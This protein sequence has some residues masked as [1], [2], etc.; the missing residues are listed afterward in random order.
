M[1]ISMP[2]GLYDTGT[3]QYQFYSYFTVFGRNARN[4]EFVEG[5]GSLFAVEFIVRVFVK[6][7]NEKIA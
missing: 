4:F 6:R 5:A 7:K 3:E 2:V 1:C